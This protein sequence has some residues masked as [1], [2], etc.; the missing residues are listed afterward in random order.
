[1]PLYL[2]TSNRLE[3]LA[4]ECAEVLR[5]PL[6][7]PFTPELVVVQSAGMQRWLSMELAKRFGA[8][9][10]CRFPF[11]NVMVDELFRACLPDAPDDAPFE[12]ERMAWRVM[13]LLPE[14]IKK[15][16]F[17]ALKHYLGDET[18][19]LKAWQLA[20]KIAYLFDQYIIFRPE[21]LAAWEGS[22]QD[23]T[24][25]AELWRALVAEA[26]RTHRA[27]LLE[28]FL[29]CMSAGGSDA[30]KGLPRRISVF[31]IS[32]LP[33]F[34]MRVLAAVAA[35][36]DVRL[37]VLNPCREY[38][39]EIMGD[40]RMA[41]E[42]ERKS[43][44]SGRE[45]HLEKG[46][47]LLAS[48]GRQGR[49]FL[50]LIEELEAV[51]GPGHSFAD[52]GED[53]LLHMI[54]GD[55]LD[56][57]DRGA[58]GSGRREIDPADDSVSVHSCH[59]P[60]RECEVLRDF[61]LDAMERI[62]GLEPHDILVM[63]PDIEA[64][65]PFIQAV[66][67]APVDDPAYIPYSI[68]DRSLRAESRV[69]DAFFGILSLP[70]ARYGAERVL[71]LLDCRPVRNRFEIDESELPLLREW[72]AG[73]NIRWGIDA[74]DRASM[75][76]PEL[77]ENTWRHGIERM[78]LGYAMP[79]EGN[80]LFR[81][82]FP[83]DAIE[84]GISGLLGR[85]LDFIEALR[86]HTAPLGQ[87]RPPSQW[88]ESLSSLL[89]ALFLSDEES[90]TQC[91]RIR[92][93]V[94][95]LGAH[96]RDAG[97]EGAIDLPTVVSILEGGLSE[98]RQAAR[99]LSGGITFCAMLPMRSIPFS[100]VCLIGMN[101]DAY[102]RREEVLGFDLIAHDRRPGDRSSRAEDRY[103]FLEAIISARERLYISYTGQSILDNSAVP[104]SVL[105]SELLDYLGQGYAIAGAPAGEALVRTHRLQ[106]FSPHYFGGGRLFSY[107][108]NGCEAARALLGEKSR[109]G[110]FIE[111]PLPPATM[112]DGPLPLDDFLRF[113]ENPVRFLLVKRLSLHLREGPAAID[114]REPIEF[115]G[116]ERYG[117]NRLL[118]ETL[119]ERRNPMDVYERARAEGL[120]PHGAAGEYSYRVL[121]PEAQG[122]A[123]G[124]RPLLEGGVLPPLE[125]ELV[126][127]DLTLSGRLSDIYQAGALQYRFGRVRA[128]D[129][130]RAWIRHLVLLSAA[131]SDY[132]KTSRLVCSDASFAMEE[133]DEARALLERLIALYLRGLGEPLPFFPESSLAYAEA[134]FDGKIETALRRASEKWLG[135]GYGA[136]GE[137]SDPYLDLCYHGT[138]P[139]GDEFKKLATDILRPML[140][141]QRE[142]RR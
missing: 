100:V 9:A 111:S 133:F 101:D 6:D 83:F 32:A 51:T 28:G 104:P 117:F 115:E 135:S 27:A 113:F 98:E 20:S 49:E 66:F 138:N 85:L 22:S 70:A 7:S 96:S 41:R 142:E 2:H 72:I 80:R 19:T 59:G 42:L 128:M 18:G 69:A 125:I 97:F 63:T 81:G 8:W 132:P 120:L 118:F 30:L 123:E 119:L 45:L 36:V 16:A 11:P 141:H 105:V 5:E 139:L 50:N 99:F 75:G 65:A 93:A 35:H 68:A 24:W 23:K 53:S 40:R 39:G 122:F 87:S 46:N 60:M 94:G 14:H 12:R 55:I 13:R 73:V 76:L 21:M 130:I 114:P 4:E 44:R 71:E 102:P 47:S 91:E 31:G 140:E 57:V 116:L 37:F 110:R 64:Y 95:A 136:A 78:L 108:G 129:R 25:Q 82:V 109:C 17:K 107:S 86:A 88:E 52:P 84:G 127:R 92:R 79:A 89:D 103:V 121:L 90:E 61:M 15:P 26:G 67:D 38:W 43:P 106:A 29:R 74:S 77:K 131:G 137:G 56:L 124:L 33:L 112:G 54:Q 126:A 48:M 58:A 1:M 134:V 62:P 3:I 34:H 10:N